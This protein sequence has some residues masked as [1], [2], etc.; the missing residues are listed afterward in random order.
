MLSTLSSI[1][2]LLFFY[3]IHDIYFIIKY[4]YLS[5]AAA[6]C[7]ERQYRCAAWC[8]GIRVV[9][10]LIIFWVHQWPNTGLNRLLHFFLFIFLHSI[11]SIAYIFDMYG[12]AIITTLIFVP[13]LFIKFCFLLKHWLKIML[14]KSRKIVMTLQKL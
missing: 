2:S 9:F 5:F 3:K 11:V 14:K 4:F 7:G 13:H 1:L 8:Y 12:M 6:A 10:L